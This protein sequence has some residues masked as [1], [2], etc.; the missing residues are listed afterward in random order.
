MQGETGA[1]LLRGPQGARGGSCLRL[2]CLLGLLEGKELGQGRG[3]CAWN[4]W[5]WG[6]YFHVQIIFKL[7]FLL[8]GEWITHLETLSLLPNLHTSFFLSICLLFIFLAFLAM[9]EPLV[10]CSIGLLRKDILALFLTFRGRHSLFH[11]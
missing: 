2:P 4:P 5:L 6:R 11:L 7:I 3:G 9:I 10:K 1:W 8:G